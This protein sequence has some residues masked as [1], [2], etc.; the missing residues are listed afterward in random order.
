MDLRNLIFEMMKYRENHLRLME[1]KVMLIKNQIT[2]LA[3]MFDEDISKLEK[4]QMNAMLGTL[5]DILSE[6]LKGE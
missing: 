1:S 6:D 4:D 3:C 2:L 5:M